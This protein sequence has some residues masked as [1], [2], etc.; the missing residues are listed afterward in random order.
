MSGGHFEYSQWQVH[1]AAEDIE[2]QIAINDSTELN[3][4]GVTKGHNYSPEV[5]E[6]FKEA[7]HTIHQAAEMMQRVDWLL[8]GDDGPDSFLRRWKEEVRPYWKISE[9]E[10]LPQEEQ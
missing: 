4:W 10:T 3:E 8:S 1:E 5:I 7:A 2:R 9:P 6:R